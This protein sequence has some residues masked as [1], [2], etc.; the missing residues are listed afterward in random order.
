MAARKKK[1]N[2]RLLKPAD[3]K[4]TLERYGVDYTP[5][6]GGLGGQ[7]PI[8]SIVEEEDG[9]IVTFKNGDVWEIRRRR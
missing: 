1:W 9:L 3:W 6:L 4:M 7:V 5:P 2:Y 8:E